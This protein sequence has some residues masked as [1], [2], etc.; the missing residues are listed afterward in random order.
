MNWLSEKIYKSVLICFFLCM[1]IN[2]CK[3]EYTSVIPY[4]YVNFSINPTNFI[5]FNIPGGSV[6]FRN[7][8]FGG[9]IVVNNWGDSNM[10]FPAF[11]STRPH[12]ISSHTRVAFN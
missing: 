3:D 2:G 12:Q 4:V 10:P 8:G 1:G 9:I 7:A 6:Y 11:D 5:E